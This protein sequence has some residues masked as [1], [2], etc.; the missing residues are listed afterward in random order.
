MRAYLDQENTLTLLREWV[1]HYAAVTKMMDSIQSS[2]GLDVDGPMSETVWKLFDEYTSTLACE[3]G[4]Y[5]NWLCWYRHEAEM[6]KKKIM[7]AGYD[8]N[9]KRIE[10]LAHLCEL[11][12]ESRK[13]KP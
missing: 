5:D 13:R 3:V 2:I 1:R 4:D 7:T 11:I 12:V 6:G 9:T 8:G 10:T